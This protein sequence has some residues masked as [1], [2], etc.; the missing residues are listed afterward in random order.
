MKIYLNEISGLWNAIDTLYMSKRSWTREKEEHIKD[1]YAKHFDRWGMK[2]KEPDAEMQ[3]L[4]D[5]TFKWAAHHITIGRFL[6]FAFTVEGIHRGAQDDFDA[7]AARFNNRIIR[8]STRLA[9]FDGTREKSDW[10]KG[11]ILTTDEML[12]FYGVPIPDRYHDAASG[13]TYVR[14][15]GGYVL[16]GEEKNKDVTRGLL[17]LAIPSNFLVRC[18]CTEFAHVLKQRDK[19]S[20]AAPELRDCV[21]EMLSLL[22]AQ[23]PQLNRD[24]FYKVEN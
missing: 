16:Q 1:L 9:S 4:M 13:K 8:S 2:V 11:K 6:D 7:H 20:H 22:Q 15:P 18:N 5:T 3:A 21:E 10:Y 14:V 24:F 17:P 12:S 23:I 19:N